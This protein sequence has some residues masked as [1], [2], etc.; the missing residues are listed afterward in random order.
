MTTPRPAPPCRP[1]F[2]SSGTSSQT[3]PCVT[4][5]LN[6]FWRSGGFWVGGLR[7]ASWLPVC[8][9]PP[10]SQHGSHV[11]SGGAISGGFPNTLYFMS[12]EV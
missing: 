3:R 9:C 2:T 4:Q 5:V 10:G 1:A 6:D 11:A 8:V 12:Y 7:F